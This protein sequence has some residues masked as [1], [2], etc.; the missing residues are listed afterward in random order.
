[1]ASKQ[2]TRPAGVD[3]AKIRDSIDA[4]DAKLHAQR[5]DRPLSETLFCAD[6]LEGRAIELLIEPRW[7]QLK[8][9]FA[10]DL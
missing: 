8:Q 1:M 7:K 3:L 4:V 2:G 6:H 10:L 5:P 9:P